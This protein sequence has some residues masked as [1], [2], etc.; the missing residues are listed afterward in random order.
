MTRTIRL[1]CY[2]CDREDLD[3]IL[4]IPS[5]WIDVLDVQSHEESRRPVDFDDQTRAASEWYTHL[6]TCPDCQQ[7][8]LTNE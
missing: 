2:T 5:D 8:E 1:A 4:K 7:E 6:G 3:G